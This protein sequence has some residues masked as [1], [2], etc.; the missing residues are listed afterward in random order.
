MQPTKLVRLMAILNKGNYQLK[1]SLYQASNPKKYV[2][3][4]VIHDS[5]KLPKT[6]LITGSFHT[7]LNI[8]LPSSIVDLTLA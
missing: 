6:V 7:L 5:I 8:N 4:A 2:P 1:T 3:N